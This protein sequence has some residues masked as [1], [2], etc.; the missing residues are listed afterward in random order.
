MTNSAYI[1]GEKV[2][3]FFKHDSVEL[4]ELLDRH[5]TRYYSN[6]EGLHYPSMAGNVDFIRHKPLELSLM[7]LQD[8]ILKGYKIVKITVQALYFKAIMKKPE[9]LIK[10][11]LRNL[12]E[13]VR[14][15]YDKNRYERNALETSRQIDITLSIKRRREEAKAAAGL[16]AALTALQASEE[17]A[18]ADLLREYSTPVEASSGTAIAIPL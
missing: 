16:E 2:A 7:D 1:Y 14:A 9:K 12:E 6:S 15:Q 11:E 17:A 13:Q 4:Q 3:E 18:L 10:A 5:L 8:E